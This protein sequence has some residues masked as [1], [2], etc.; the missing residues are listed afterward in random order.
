[1][2]QSDMR[3]ESHITELAEPFAMLLNAVSRHISVLESAGL[4]RRRRAGASSWVLFNPAPSMRPPHGSK[5]R[6]SPLP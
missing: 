6:T 4:W 5:S 2:L 3:R 1:M